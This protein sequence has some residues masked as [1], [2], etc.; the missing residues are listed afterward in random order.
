MY[1]QSPCLTP[2]NRQEIARP[3]WTES[4]P[5]LNSVA[6]GR[7]SGQLPSPPSI[8]PSSERPSMTRQAPASGQVSVPDHSTRVGTRSMFAV[9]ASISIPAPRR[10]RGRRAGP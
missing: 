8:N 2:W 5:M 4:L 6:I 7:L 10:R 9:G 1:S 3:G